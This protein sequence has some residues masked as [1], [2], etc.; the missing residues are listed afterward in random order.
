MEGCEIDQDLSLQCRDGF[1]SIDEVVPIALDIIDTLEIDEDACEVTAMGLTNGNQ[2][3]T[4]ALEEE[5]SNFGEVMTGSRQNGTLVN[6][7]TLNLMMQSWRQELKQQF[8]KLARGRYAFAVKYSNGTW[9]LAGATRGF[10]LDTLTHNSGTAHEDKN[11]VDLVLS[12]KEPEP[13]PVISAAI[14]ASLI[15]PAS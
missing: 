6:V 13:A 12:V 3:Y 5:T 14:V 1:G 2:G 8:R 9:V 7:Q 10:M 15:V 11:G 4:Y